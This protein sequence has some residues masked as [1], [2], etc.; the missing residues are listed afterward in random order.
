MVKIRNLLNEFYANTIEN[1]NKIQTSND[2][3]D[4]RTNC[5]ERPTHLNQPYQ[6]QN[7]MRTEP[8]EKLS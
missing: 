5:F 7:D 6:S 1:H 4:V 8:M 2:F 3:D